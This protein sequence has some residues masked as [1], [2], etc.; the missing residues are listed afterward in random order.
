MSYK[1]LQN[2][3][4]IE[5]DVNKDNTIINAIY[6]QIKNYG[7]DQQRKAIY[8]EDDI[9]A[10]VPKDDNRFTF[11]INKQ[12]V[13]LGGLDLMLAAVETSFSMIKDENPN[14]MINF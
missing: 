9:R 11:R 6:N 5:R 4:N 2:I 1:I 12:N 14:Q 10:E 8:Q 7:L 3:D 13:Q